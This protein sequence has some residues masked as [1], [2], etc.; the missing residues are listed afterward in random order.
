MKVKK[1]VRVDA[2]GFVVAFV[3]LSEMSTSVS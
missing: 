3:P 1:K 2:A